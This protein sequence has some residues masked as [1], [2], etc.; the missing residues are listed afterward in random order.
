M[1][2]S[3]RHDV[4]P[5]LAPTRFAVW[6]RRVGASRS[7]LDCR[8]VSGSGF[9]GRY[10]STLT[11]LAGEMADASGGQRFLCRDV[12]LALFSLAQSEGQL[13]E[14]RAIAAGTRLDI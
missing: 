6:D 14:A 13:A 10:L 2:L 3:P 1:R 9:Y 7:A 11:V 12:D 8:P 4:S 5:S